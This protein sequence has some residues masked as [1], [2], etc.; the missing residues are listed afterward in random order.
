MKKQ[1]SAI[2]RSLSN[3]WFSQ[4]SLLRRHIRENVSPRRRQ[5]A[6]KAE[7]AGGATLEE[8][9]IPSD[10]QVQQLRRPWKKSTGDAVGEEAGVRE[11]PRARRGRGE[12]RPSSTG[13]ADRRLV[14]LVPD[15]HPRHPYRGLPMMAEGK[16]GPRG[17]GTRSEAEPPSQGRER[18]CRENYLLI[19]SN[20]PLVASSLS[21]LPFIPHLFPF[22]R[23]LESNKVHDSSIHR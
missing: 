9:A 19:E 21:F 15:S 7:N 18:V 2:R 6:A 16:M 20:L 13:A 23:I 14:S 1:G 11:Q 3:D 17:G 10:H 4:K 5:M 22:P 12:P 8:P